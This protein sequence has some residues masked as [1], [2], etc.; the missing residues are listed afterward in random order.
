M[1]KV[2]RFYPQFLSTGVGSLPHT[3]VAEALRC[4]MRNVPEAPHWPQLPKQGAES[5]F[6]GQ[7]LRAL[8]ETGVIAGYGEL[9]FQVEADDWAERMAAFYELYLQAAEG[10]EGAWESFGFGAVGGEGFDGFCRGVAGGGAGQAVLL[11][12]QLSGPLTLGL[13]ITDRQRRASYY[14]DQLRDM[15]VKALAVHA[16]WQTRRLLGLGLPALVMIDDPGLYACGA[17]THITLRRE[18]LI[19]DL[20]VIADGILAEGGIPGAHVCA[21]MDW[22]ILFD[23]KLRVINFDAY[24]YFTS[25]LVLAEQL[26]DFLKKGGVVSWGIVPTNE[27]A[28]SESP[29]SLRERLERNIAELVRRGVNEDR[30]RLQSI[31]T[32][33]CGTGTLSMELAEH[34]YRLLNG[35]NL[36]MQKEAGKELPVFSG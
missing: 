1:D 2:P 24:G 16:Q 14:D 28:W 17:S 13:Q 32:P 26:D 35:L 7:Y 20:D 36:A 29:E 31:L 10:N 18:Q 33:S 25:M 9:A 5:S 8:V 3:D 11:K 23:S 6:A 12:G 34:I 15:L 4:I 21:G 19:E 30:L 27:L 22:T